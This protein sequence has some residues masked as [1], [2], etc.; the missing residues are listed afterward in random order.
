MTEYERDKFLRE[1]DNAQSIDDLKC[2]VAAL[3]KSLPTETIVEK[4]AREKGWEPYK[5]END[6]VIRK[7]DKIFDNLMRR[8]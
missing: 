5:P 4:R 1:L 3:I 8:L 7:I 6:P 2:V